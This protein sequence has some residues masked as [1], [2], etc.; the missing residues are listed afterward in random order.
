[1]ITTPISYTESAYNSDYAASLVAATFADRKRYKPTSECIN[2]LLQRRTDLACA[3]FLCEKERQRLVE[4]NKK[5]E[6]E[7]ECISE[8]FQHTL[9]NLP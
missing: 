4:E 5:L 8:D 2:Y 7:V 9:D 6:D 3:L 1:M